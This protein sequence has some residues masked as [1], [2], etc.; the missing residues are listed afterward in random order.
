MSEPKYKDLKVDAYTS[1]CPI[2]VT[3]DTKIDE[4]MAIMEN[5]TIRHVPVVAD[6]R[7]VGM[8]SQRDLAVIYSLDLPKEFLAKDVMIDHPYCVPCGTPLEVVA[9]E[10]SS[11]KIGSVVVIDGDQKISGIFTATDALN[12]LIDI[13]RDEVEIE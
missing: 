8:I 7:P 3:E 13:L 2:V 5:N 9:L 12:A 1:P 4:V 11:R 10:L 6:G